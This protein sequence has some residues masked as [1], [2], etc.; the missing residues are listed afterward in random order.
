MLTE[1]GR[2]AETAAFRG[3]D[4]FS[5]IFA[6][7]VTITIYYLTGHLLESVLEWTCPL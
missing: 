6:Q 4:Y 3:R 2:E 5:W 1:R 7:D